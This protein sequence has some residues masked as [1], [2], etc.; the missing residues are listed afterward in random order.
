MRNTV[1]ISHRLKR[2]WLDDLLDRLV[3]TRDEKELRA[4]VDQRLR[5]ELPGKDARAKAA[6]I[7]LRIWSG[8]EPKHAALRDRAVAMLPRISG[9]E[10]IWLHWGMSALAYPFF[11]DL[12]EVIGRMLTLQDDITNAQVQ[13][14][15]KTAWGDRETSKEAAGKLITSMVDWEVLRATKTKG[16]FLLARKMTTTVTDLQLWLLEAMLS[17]SASDEI[18]AQQLLR[19]PESFPFSFTV[20]VA[21]LRRHEGF[22]IHRQGLDMDMVSVR[23]VKVAPPPMPPVKEKKPKKQKAEEEEQPTLFEKPASDVLVEAPVG[24]SPKQEPIPYR[25]LV[26]V[27]NLM[28]R[29]DRIDMGEFV[30]TRVGLQFEALREKL[31]SKGVFHE[32][33][34]LEKTYNELP[35]CPGLAPS[36]LGG[37]PN[38]IED[39]LF[40]L[41]LFKVGDVA[42][43]RQAVVKPNGETLTQYPYRMMNSLNSNSVL[44][45][46]FGDDDPAQWPGF[47]ASLRAS[48]SWD[49]QWFFVAR[50]FFL[51]GGAKEF[52]PGWDEVDRIV[53]YATALEAALVPEGEFS[54]SRCANRAALLCSSA[55]EE[56]KVV[57]SLV[58]KLYDIRSSI[59]HGSVLGEEDST[60]L[61]ENSREVELRVRQVLVAAVQQ[62][63][64]D[65]DGRTP[66]LRSLFDVTDEKR[67]EFALQMFR[68]IKTEA[69]RN[70][71]A[72]Q[73][74]K[75]QAKRK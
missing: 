57:S 70:K 13:T 59:V 15:L 20:S 14:R 19:L 9:Q 44:T 16:H 48:Q 18:E 49:A 11:R 1:G 10:R 32:D 62:S 17:A 22:N 23:Q 67:G 50:R 55:P 52:N 39:I 34:L 69:V 7:L 30:L 41:R 72:A 42:F 43:V 56:Q 29:A 33:W 21:D 27:R 66:F 73:I 45:T 61:K 71:T 68:E 51:Y 58:K 6:G 3:Q 54:R 38:D 46:E 2:G 37:I 53:D 28:A 25:A 26:L 65:D 4:F 31:S 12:A 8:V 75:L 60:W 35:S 40:L 47:A 64:P 74:A 24:S 5:D 63:P 36:G